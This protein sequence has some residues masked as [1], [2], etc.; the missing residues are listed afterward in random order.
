MF[1]GNSRILLGKNATDSVIGEWKAVAPVGAVNGNYGITGNADAEVY[2][3]EWVVSRDILMV[4]GIF[5]NIINNTT[6]T[7]A[8][9]LAKFESSGWSVLTGIAGATAGVRKISVGVNELG[10]IASIRDIRNASDTQRILI[11]GDFNY[12]GG[13]YN[14]SYLNIS[15]YSIDSGWSGTTFFN[16]DDIVHAISNIEFSS[17]GITAYIVGEFG[18]VNTSPQDFSVGVARYNFNISLGTGTL[19]GLGAIFDEFFGEVPRSIYNDTEND[20][21]IIQSPTIRIRFDYDGTYDFGN[22]VNYVVGSNSENNEAGPFPKFISLST[23]NNRYLYSSVSPVEYYDYNSND[24][25]N[26]NT[27]NSA[28]IGISD[29]DLIDYN[30]GT[31]LVCG[32]REAGG[33][34]PTGNRLF[35]Y[36][37]DD[38]SFQ[39][40]PV[41]MPDELINTGNVNAVT[42]DQN[43]GVVYVGGKFV[44]QDSDGNTAWN[45]A[46]FV[47]SATK[48]TPS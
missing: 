3:L 44:F 48:F 41:P 11:G 13:I 22:D 43:T 46:K 2:C 8:N 27:S 15:Q 23:K 39:S 26:W 47:P 21:L 32:I 7:S 35:F 40:K 6:T 14:N 20:K 18:N 45:V 38:N 9:S 10:K 30:S 24:W 33:V 4:G 42:I 17:S 1:F 12:A 36:K 34:S 5:D 25:A 29:F 28:T 16:S 37:V 19:T 31:Y